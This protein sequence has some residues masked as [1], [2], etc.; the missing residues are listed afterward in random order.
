M[1]NDVKNEY[2][3]YL[4][5]GRAEIK[6]STDLIVCKLDCDIEDLREKHPDKVLISCKWIDDSICRYELE[7]KSK[8]IL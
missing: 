3:K 6:E 4:T 2:R 5:V 7:D 8:Y 1:V